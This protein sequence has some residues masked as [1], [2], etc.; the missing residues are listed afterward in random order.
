MVDADNRPGARGTMT[1][2]SAPRSTVT[3]RSRARGTMTSLAR[4]SG[5]TAS[6]GGLAARLSCWSLPSSGIP[7]CGQGPWAGRS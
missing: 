6:R 1:S 2:R 5:G 4:A 7:C 3:S